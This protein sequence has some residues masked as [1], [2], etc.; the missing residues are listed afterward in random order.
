MN[1]CPQD[2]WLR[3]KALGAFFHLLTADRPDTM[4]YTGARAFAWRLDATHPTTLDP[5][6]DA[7]GAYQPT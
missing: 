7:N 3:T 6:K 1:G 4:I 2:K 5:V